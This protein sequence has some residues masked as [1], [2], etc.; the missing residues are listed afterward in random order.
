M[1]ISEKESKI[2]G[3][4]LQSKLFVNVIKPTVISSVKGE[5]KSYTQNKKS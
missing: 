5:I 3:E 4:I 2:P 1:G